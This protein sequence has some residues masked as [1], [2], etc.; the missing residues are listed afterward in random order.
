MRMKNFHIDRFLRIAQW[1]ERASRRE[2]LTVLAIMTAAYMVV[3]IGSLSFADSLTVEQSQQQLRHAVGRCSFA[4][5]IYFCIS[6]SWI[7]SNMTTRQ[8]SI[9]FKMLPGSDLEKYLVR[10]AYTIVVW[11]AIGLLAFTIADILRIII[12]LLTG[13]TWVQSGWPLFFDAWNG[14]WRM[15]NDGTLIACGPHPLAVAGM[16]YLQSFYI[17]GGTLL[18]RHKLLF[19]TIALFVMMTLALILLTHY[20]ESISLINDMYPVRVM[21]LAVLGVLILF[22]LINYRLAYTLFVRKQIVNNKLFNV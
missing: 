16:M 15:Y 7:F 13:A 21:V 11:A 18:N 12:S 14:R 22:T 9:T 6:G 5:F 10:M 4:F 20:Q 3:F 19:T 17:L 8:Q 1:T 2:Y